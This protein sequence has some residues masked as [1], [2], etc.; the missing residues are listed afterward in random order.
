MKLIKI[1]C[2]DGA[3]PKEVKIIKLGNWTVKQL[4]DG[5]V[6]IDGTLGT[7]YALSPS[8]S[9]NLLKEYKTK[10]RDLEKAI[11]KVEQLKSKL[12]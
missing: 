11:K 4:S 3:Y 9:K 6:L 12:K 10:T 1:K 5:K 2:I 7:E 8:H